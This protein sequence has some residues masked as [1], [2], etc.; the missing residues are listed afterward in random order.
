MLDF[1]LDPDNTSTDPNTPIGI[2]NLAAKN[3]IDSRLNDGSNQIG[4]AP[5]SDGLPY[6]DY[7]GYIPVNNADQLTNLS[8]WQ[9]KYFADGKG[10][11]FAPECLTPHWGKVSPLA[12]DS[13]SQ[14]RP[15]PPPAIGSK[16]LAEEVKEVVEMQS[17][18]TDEHRALVEF[19]RDGPK[20]VQQA[21]HWFIFAQNVSERDNHT[22]DDDVK[23]YFLVE[24]AAMDAFIAAW[25]AKMYYDF[26]R[27]YALVHAY[28]KDKNIKAWGG[29]DTGM[30]QVK[31]SEWRPYSP[32]TFLCPPFPSYVSGHSCVSAA[33]SETLRLFTGS[34]QFGQEV[35]IVPGLLTEPENIGDTVTLK[36]NT[37]TETADMAGLS[38]VLGGYHIQSDNV[39]GLKLGRNVAQV[40]WKKYLK[41]TQGEQKGLSYN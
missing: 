37:F 36:F 39:E 18:L 10:G 17:N 26:A 8:R 34:D 16:V 1:G 21:G 7:T 38:R 12:L 9:P 20:S 30:V 29:P 22:L 40:V 4:N 3:V 5:N 35:K 19:M 24:V 31:G 14:F 23:M 15:G 28:Y 32:D 6:S 33:C 25:D 2:G 11:K 41:H 27:P 13:P